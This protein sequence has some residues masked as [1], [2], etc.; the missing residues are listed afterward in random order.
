MTGQASLVDERDL[1]GDGV[2]DVVGMPGS[3][4]FVHDRNGIRA[5]VDLD[6]R[7]VVLLG[8]AAEELDETF[9]L[10]RR[11]TDHDVQIGPPLQHAVEQA[12]QKVDVQRAFVRLVDDQ[13]AVARE[14]RILARFLQQDAVGHELDARVAAGL[15]VETDGVADLSAEHA[16][17]L[18][19]DAP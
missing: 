11:R 6:D 7:D 3:E 8:G 14:V 19:G 2:G 15:V 10:N 17:L 4:G 16:V 18:L 9:R 1:P 5:G 13:H 12:E